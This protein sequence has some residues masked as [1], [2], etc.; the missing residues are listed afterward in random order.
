MNIDTTA[1]TAEQAAALAL[2]EMA[3]A[4]N[5]KALSELSAMADRRHLTA[6]IQGIVAVTMAHLAADATAATRDSAAQWQ[7]WA[8]GL[9][10]TL[11]A[12]A[13]TPADNA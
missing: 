6:H 5:L 7:Q 4:E 2:G 9:S 10:D 3:K 1:T 8:L 12:S 13:A 11:V